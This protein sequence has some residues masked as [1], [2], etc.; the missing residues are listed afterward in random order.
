MKNRKDTLKLFL[1]DQLFIP[2]E[3]GLILIPDEYI[4]Q[5]ITGC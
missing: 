5:N 4:W 3:M 1:K 2:W